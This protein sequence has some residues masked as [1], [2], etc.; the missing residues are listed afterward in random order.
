MA[1]TLFLKVMKKN[2]VSHLRNLLFHALRCKLLLSLNQCFSSLSVIHSHLNSGLGARS[3]VNLRI[4]LMMLI[5]I[6]IQKNSDFNF[7]PDL[8]SEIPLGGTREHHKHLTGWKWPVCVCLSVPP[9]STP[10]SLHPLSMLVHVTAQKCLASAGSWTLIP[11][12]CA[13][14]STAVFVNP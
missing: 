12:E 4:K 6:I 2:Q 9:S 7:P 8:F 1:E 13:L 3:P 5:M 10:Y 14:Y 11:T